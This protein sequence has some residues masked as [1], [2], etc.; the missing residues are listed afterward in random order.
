MADERNS[1]VHPVQVE[2]GIAYMPPWRRHLGAY[3]GGR[4]DNGAWISHDMN[5]CV[6]LPCILARR[7]VSSS[8]RLCNPLFQHQCLHDFSAC[9]LRVEGRGRGMARPEG[10][11]DKREHYKP[12]LS[13]D[14]VMY[15][16]LG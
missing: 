15:D 13:Q 7:R 4:I 1:T 9:V 3:I 16:L 11:I 5:E 8:V 2:T 10:L 14:M 6:F 12:L